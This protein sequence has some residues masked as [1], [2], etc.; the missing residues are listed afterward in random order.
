MEHFFYHLNQINVNFIWL[1]FGQ[2]HVVENKP[3]V[4]IVSSPGD[5]TSGTIRVTRPLY[6]IKPEDLVIVST[7]KRGSYVFYF[8][9]AYQ[10]IIRF[11]C[12]YFKKYFIYL[13]LIR[14]LMIACH[15]SLISFAL[16]NSIHSKTVHN[17]TI[18]IHYWLVHSKNATITVRKYLV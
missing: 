3:H 9:L 16:I 17:Y 1:T 5:T 2:M 7:V 14:S 8:Y 11:N 6:K 10:R 13:W 15:I 12:Y 18:S 4:S